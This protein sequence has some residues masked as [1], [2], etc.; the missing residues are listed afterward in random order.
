M[1]DYSGCD[2]LEALKYFFFQATLCYLNQGFKYNEKKM[3]RTKG[4]AMTPKRT[5]FSLNNEPADR[6]S[7]ISSDG[8]V[9][10]PV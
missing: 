3:S 5:K 8:K 2:Y 6:K 4:Q 10:K 9:L 1:Y 7:S